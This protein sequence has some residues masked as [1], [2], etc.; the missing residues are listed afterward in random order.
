MSTETPTII[1]FTKDNGPLAQIWLAA[2]M[3]NL[4]KNSILQTDLIESTKELVKVSIDD[5]TN[6]TLRTS[7][8]MLQGIIRV[9]SKK[10]NF[11]L[12][13]IKDTLNK[14]NLIFKNNNNKFDNL[15]INNTTNNNLN[16]LNIIS[17][18]D[19][20]ILKDAVTENE[21]L[22]VSN[23]DFL[24]NLNLPNDLLE[25][26]FS[27]RKMQGASTTT[28]FDRP[29]EVGRKRKFDEALD[30]DTSSGLDFSFNINSSLSKDNGNT[31]S[32]VINTQGTIN[33]N[34]DS[35]IIPVLND[36]D[37][38]FEE[39][40]DNI[41]QDWDLGITENTD[42]YSVELGRRADENNLSLINDN[43]PQFDFDLDIEKD[44]EIN[45]DISENHES[46]N[47]NL[48]KPNIRQRRNSALIHAIKITLDQKT[49]L[50]DRNSSESQ[51]QALIQSQ[52][53][54]EFE[55]IIQK[56]INNNLLEIDN[57]RLTTKTIWDHFHSSISY[58]PSNVLSLLKNDS[59]FTTN[60]RQKTIDG[61]EIDNTDDFSISLQNDVDDDQ[62][63][64]LQ[65]NDNDMD[66]SLDPNLS[67]VDDTINTNTSSETLQSQKVH[68]KEGDMISKSL[69]HMANTLRMHFIDDTTNNNIVTFDSILEEVHAESQEDTLITKAEASKSFFHM[70]SMANS[71]CVELEQN[72]PFGSIK[73]TK[74]S[75]LFTKLIEV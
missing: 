40:D 12:S 46:N 57:N 7:G 55:K 1:K 37:F 20:L 17:N 30:F 59:N 22:K 34:N 48:I 52:P 29:I 44:N 62:D 8:D 36:D 31:T 60:K 47:I 4:S 70:L 21:V 26:Q 13:D 41:N 18:I 39:D 2:N 71:D 14:I 63:I 25:N 24:N 3:N 61:S 32:N 23:L 33:S 38:G 9:Y 56:K 35:V 42:D 72:E 54:I 16:K 15:I 75:A 43:Q 66:F 19:Q 65:I 45:D 5:N 49:E 67:D 53:P 27:K 64:D 6:I 51:S 11:L 10:T 58:L 68:T 28:P 50:N 69:I 73:I 74:S